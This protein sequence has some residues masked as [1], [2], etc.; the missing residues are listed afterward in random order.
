MRHT[1]RSLTF[2]ATVAVSVLAL[3]SCAGSTASDTATTT[4]E[5]AA[6]AETA[7]SSGELQEFTADV[8]ADNWFEMYVNGELVGEDS[9]PITTER[10][11]NKETFTFTASY[12]LT[13]AIEAKD[14]KETDS[15][16]EYIGLANQQMGDGGLI[17]QVTDASGNVITATDGSWES[18]VIQRAPLDTSCENA[19]DPDTACTFEVTDVADDWFA[20]DFDSSSWTSAGV[21]S[22]AEVSPKD[23][24]NEVSWD[25]SAELIWGTSLTQDNTILFR[26]TVDAP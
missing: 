14:F 10:S 24:Y 8:W 21:F 5:S 25:S 26:Q 19:A 15:G 4:V 18:L 9:V 3:A 23:G 1:A 20:T 7:E 2:A 13:I 11:F 12:P 16:I 6:P 22:A 17:A